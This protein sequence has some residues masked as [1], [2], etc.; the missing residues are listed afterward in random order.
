MIKCHL[1]SNVVFH[2][3]HLPSKAVEIKKNN[4]SPK[5]NQINLLLITIKPNIHIYNNN[6]PFNN[7]NNSNYYYNKTTSEYLG[8][9]LI[10]NCLEVIET[11]NTTY[12][13]LCNCCNSLFYNIVFF[14]GLLDIWSQTDE[15]YLLYKRSWDSAVPSSWQ[16]VCYSKIQFFFCQNPNSTST[17]PNIR[18]RS[19]IT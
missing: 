18:E 14:R 4:V 13:V 8:F 6:N 3:H 5:E 17:E 9:D 16:S 2:Q 7:N 15:D 11:K 12:F 19:S 1:P 10:V